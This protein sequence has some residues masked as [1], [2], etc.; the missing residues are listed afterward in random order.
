MPR[1]VPPHLWFGYHDSNG[2]KTSAYWA[3]PVS[4]TRLFFS[5]RFAKSSKCSVICLRTHSKCTGGIR[6]QGHP[7]LTN[8]PCPLCVSSRWFLGATQAR[9]RLGLPEAVIANQILRLRGL[10][11]ICRWK[12]SS[13]TLHGNVLLGQVVTHLPC[14]V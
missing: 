5:S 7:I 8:F 6:P 11:W 10:G 9:P 13:L 14:G 3:L 12:Q 2:S 1:Q 4:Q